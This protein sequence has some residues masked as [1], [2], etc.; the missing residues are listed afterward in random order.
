M[1]LTDLNKDYQLQQVVVKQLEAEAATN[2]ELL[3]SAQDEISDLRGRTASA[4]AQLAAAQGELTRAR[5]S[6]GSSAGSSDRT[7]FTP[8]LPS[9]RAT[10][11]APPRS[12]QR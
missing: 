9:Y 12:M 6:A 4:E 8:S 7:R 3:A 10:T 1:E 11:P 2:A 5:T